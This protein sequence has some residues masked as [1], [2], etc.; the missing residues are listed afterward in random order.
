MACRVHSHGLGLEPVFANGAARRRFGNLR[1]P[2]EVAARLAA[3]TE[4]QRVD[5]AETL[6]S[7]ARDVLVCA[8]ASRQNRLSYRRKLEYY[9]HKAST[10]GHDLFSFGTP[11]SG[12][13]HSKV[14]TPTHEAMPQ[15]LS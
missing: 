13:F 12:Y 6:Q 3:A 14:I 9:S 4:S 11:N 15:T 8:L 5:H 10:D 7:L 2:P 1:S